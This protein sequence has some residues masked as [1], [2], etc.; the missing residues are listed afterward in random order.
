MFLL[1]SCPQES[2]FTTICSVA[3]IP[4][5]SSTSTRPEVVEA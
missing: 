2:K 5:H 3:K 4:I 1:I